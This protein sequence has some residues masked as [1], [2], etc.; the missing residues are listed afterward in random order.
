M[1]VQI[2]DAFQQTLDAVMEKTGEVKDVDAEAAKL[3][4]TMNGPKAELTKILLDSPPNVSQQ[5]LEAALLEAALLEVF[6]ANNIDHMA[7]NALD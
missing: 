5:E 2:L 6:V 3:L 4:E 1:L 7:N